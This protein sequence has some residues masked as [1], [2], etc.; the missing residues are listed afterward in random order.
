MTRAQGLLC[1]AL[2]IGAGYNHNKEVQAWDAERAHL[3]SQIN[4]LQAEQ[5]AREGKTDRDFYAKNPKHFPAGAVSVRG[6][7]DGS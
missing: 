2:V 7:V 6:K 4:A 3:Q 1:L 5:V